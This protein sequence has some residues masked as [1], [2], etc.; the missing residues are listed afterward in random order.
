VIQA[1][2]GAGEE[3]QLHAQGEKEL[4]GS[5]A[6]SEISFPPGP[7]RRGQHGAAVWCHAGLCRA[8][9]FGDRAPPRGAGSAI[10]PG[11]RGAGWASGPGWTGTGR[12]GHGGPAP[13]LGL[14]QDEPKG[15]G[16]VWQTR[17]LSGSP[18]P[19]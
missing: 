12:D 14:V 5:S 8:V 3:I 4:L 10:A 16:G 7:Q 15:A 9:G 11:P 18:W 2:F 19:R 17:P 13:A 1:S 6:G